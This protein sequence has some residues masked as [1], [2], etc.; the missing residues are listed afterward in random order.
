MRDEKMIRIEKITAAILLCGCF[1]L[2]AVAPAFAATA[3]GLV[4]Q[5]N[6]AYEQ[7]DFDGALRSYDQ[8]A[9]KAP[10][11]PYVQYDRGNALY[12]KGDFAGALEAYEQA[13]ARS[14]APQ[15]LAKT[16]LNMG[17]VQVRQAEAMQEGDPEK[18]MEALQEGVSN[19]R[20]A[21]ELDQQLADAGRNMEVA[22]LR[23]RQ[24]Q[25]RLEQQ[26]QQQKA[27]EQQKEEMKKEL[28]KMVDRQQDL[29]QKSREQAAEQGASSSEPGAVEDQKDL[30]EKTENLTQKMQDASD[31]KDAPASEL[32]QASE[33]LQDAVE[34]QK[35]AVEAMQQQQQE[36]AAS[37]QEQAADNLQKALDALAAKDQEKNEQQENKDGQQEKKDAAG[38]QGQEQ[39]GGVAADEQDFQP[40][41]APS[42]QTAAD[43]L[44]EEKRNRLQRQRQTTGYQEVEKDW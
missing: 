12:K 35:E 26:R 25:K 1:C 33:S 10:E 32:K 34:K 27:A 6:K 42:D 30:Q 9:E 41:A 8:A 29:A 21:L 28:E 44:N 43:I 22:K 23:M 31:G 19:Y 7:G 36:K 24:L 38:K 2:V 5:G 40:Q 11:S 37:A 17:N 18:A 13:Q 15:F 4:A 3:R 14:R 20:A 16:K 39:Q